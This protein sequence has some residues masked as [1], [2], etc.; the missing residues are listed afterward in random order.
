M[1]TESFPFP[2][3]QVPYGEVVDAGQADQLSSDE[4]VLT[5]GLKEYVVPPSA[6]SL[7]TELLA[8]I[9]GLAEGIPDIADA[10]SQASSPKLGRSRTK[11]K[12]LIRYGPKPHPLPS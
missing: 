10:F 11:N 7:Q 12:T 3:Y 6:S 8:G 9:Q 1:S 4:S 2:P 5:Q